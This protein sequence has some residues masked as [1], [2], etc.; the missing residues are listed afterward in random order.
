MFAVLL[1][2]LC[3]LLIYGSSEPLPGVSPERAALAEELGEERFSEARWTG[4]FPHAPYKSASDRLTLTSEARE[5]GQE[6]NAQVEGSPR[7]VSDR[8]LVKLIEGKIEEAASSMEAYAKENP[9]DGHFLSD[10]SAVLVERSRTLRQ[11]EDLIPALVAAEKAV[12]ASPSLPE[13]RFNLAL[14]LVLLG[15]EEDAKEAWNQYL[16]IDAVSDWSTEAREHL[17]ALD[18]PTQ[19]EAWSERKDE[20][21]EA[22]LRGQSD[23]IKRDVARF[24]QP[25]RSHA[26]SLLSAWA[27]AQGEGDQ[28]KARRSLDIARA[29][30]TALAE[31]TGDPLLKQS[32][33]AIDRAA[34]SPGREQWTVLLRGHQEHAA[35]W[36]SFKSQDLK[37]AASQFQAASASLAAA[38][39]PFSSW[40]LFYL[41]VCDYQH[42][43]YDQVIT[44]LDGLV[45]DLRSTPYRAVKARALGMLGLVHLI[46]GRPEA[47]LR[48][49]EQALAGFEAL[50]ESGNVAG[51][52]P[53][54]ASGLRFVGE[55]RKAWQHRYEGMRKAQ[56]F[57]APN[58]QYIAAEEMAMATRQLG[59][60]SVA[61]RFQEE[62]LRSAQAAKSPSAVAEALRSRADLHRLRSDKARALADL[63][64]AERLS[65]QIE[66]EKLRR[67]VLGNILLIQGEI[68]RASDPRRA[69]KLLD[70]AV[71]TFQ[72]TEYHYRLARSLVERGLA[73]AALR[74]EEKAEA[75][76][77][78]AA[79][80][81]ERQ[82]KAVEPSHR[83]SYL[84]TQHAIFQ[85]NI[86]FQ[87]DH[88]RDT[89]QAFHYAER[90]RARLLLDWLLSLSLEEGSQ[91]LS[92]AE[93]LRLDEV[94]AE[95]PDDVVLVEYV[96]A[97]G[98]LFAWVLGDG[99]A[100]FQEIHLSG[101]PLESGI[102]RL[103]KGIE[104][105]NRDETR[106]AASAL[107]ERLIRP[108]AAHLPK[109]RTLVFV[110][111]GPLHTAPFAALLDEHTER[112]LV[113]DHPIG[114]APSATVYVKS[115]ARDRMLAGKATG[116]MLV[117]ADPAFDS[118]LFP[119]FSRLYEARKELAP[120]RSLFPQ[121]LGLK[122]KEATKKAFL[123]VAGDH[124]IVHFGG[125]AVSN[126]KAPLLSHLLFA[127][128]PGDPTR[129][130]LYGHELLGKRFPNTRLVVLAACSSGSGRLS[131]SEGVESLA[132]PFLAAGVPV[133]VASL[134]DVKDEDSA[135]FF[136]FFYERLK[137]G[138]DALGALR[139]AQLRMMREE[140]SK[141]SG[142]AGFVGVGGVYP[143]STE[144]R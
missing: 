82:R 89:H 57:G 66:D 54:I 52:R 9:G 138:D 61:L 142:W 134:W 123:Q 7:A 19:M 56:E 60:Y 72:D 77:A 41:A 107:Y 35:G 112:Y 8:A 42:D 131:A 108:L 23:V 128:E 102:E 133:V 73:H 104:G 36:S 135:R 11:P 51:I 96:L 14:V 38:A 126:T 20:L 43:L 141:L 2:G 85:E 84:D 39:S 65:D 15:L 80:E 62:I 122:E 59:E 5:L 143:R 111:D 70:E 33:E 10:L 13:A 98:R 47:G 109:G 117:V 44:R 140:G 87:I 58:I 31:V 16:E 100:V 137:A 88:R 124:E 139:T 101:E 71:E 144:S 32:V 120:M 110:P 116:S 18:K 49:Y 46:E 136:G 103:S 95:M 115:V 34:A 114:M 55:E 12:Q 113:E 74:D 53:Q 21:E 4:G 91:G 93:P 3:G 76:F 45:G 37:Q 28:E 75:D 125:H 132:Q 127:P 22:A 24:R 29:F 92:Q 17:A 118:A 64:E 27:E 1:L 105:K 69:V 119:D 30:A 25:A 50:G 26:E 94:L 97:R 67:S 48:A 130:V 79:E 99:K 6:I 129:G 68:E 40:S 63:S 106:A 81:C 86:F 90:R 83:A 121:A 78:A